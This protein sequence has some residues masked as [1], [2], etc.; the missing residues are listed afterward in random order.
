MRRAESASWAQGSSSGSPRPSNSFHV[1][2]VC[3]TDHITRAHGAAY[4]SGA[5]EGVR[6]SHMTKFGAGLAE[7]ISTDPCRAAHSGS[8][9]GRTRPNWMTSFNQSY[10]A[11]PL[12]PT[13]TASDLNPAP[14]LDL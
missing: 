13:R 4:E 2:F 10:S 12:P 9:F 6:N 8:M 7:R 14:K 11:P 1:G 3:M 5:T